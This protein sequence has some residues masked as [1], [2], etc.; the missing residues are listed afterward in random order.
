MSTVSS[1]R[2]ERS[3]ER[4][5]AARPAATDRPTADTAAAVAVRAV[6]AGGV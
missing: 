1:E 5:V 4:R 3:I 6:R 2:V